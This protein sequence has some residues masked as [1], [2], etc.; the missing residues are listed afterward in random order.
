MAFTTRSE[1]S[2]NWPDPQKHQVQVALGGDFHGPG[3]PTTADRAAS[4]YGDSPFDGNYNIGLRIVCRRP[5]LSAPP[6]GDVA[7]LECPAWVIERGR[8]TAAR[9]RPEPPRRPILEMVKI[10]GG[11]F[12]HPETGVE[13][14]ISPFEMARCEVTFAKWL[15]VKRWAEAHG[16]AFGR[17][18]HMGSMYWYSFPHGPD[19]PVTF[20]TWHDCAVWCNA[21]S[22]ME[23]RTPFYYTDPARTKVYRHAFVY[24]P[25]KVAGWEIVDKKHPLKKYALPRNNEP[26]L[27]EKWDAD[28]YRLPTE[29]EFECAV[30][31]GTGT[32]YFWEETGGKR[33]DYVWCIYNSGG[34]THPVGQ[35]KPNPFGLYDLIGNVYEWSNSGKQPRSR[36]PRFDTNNPKRSRYWAHGLDRY[37]YSV[38]QNPLRMGGSWFWGGVRG[39]HQQF[40]FHDWGLEYMPDVGFRVVRCEPGTHP[41]NG[42]FPLVVPTLLKFD[43]K[44][45]EDLAGAAYRGS[46]RRDGVHQ[47]TGVAKLIGIKWKVHLG[48]PIKSSPVATG[49]LVYVGSASGFHAL[50]AETGREKWKVA[51]K[52]GVESA[53]CVAKGMVYFTGMDG[54]VYAV[55]AQNGNVKWKAKPK[56]FYGKPLMSGPAMAYGIVFVH[57]GGNTIG[58]DV[59][60]GHESWRCQRGRKGR[61]GVTLHSKYVITGGE[62]VTL[63]K[64]QLLFDT[65]HLIN[66][67][68]DADLTPCVVGDLYW[69]ASS[70][71]GGYSFAKLGCGDLAARR[72]RWSHFIEQHLPQPK[73]S[74]SSCSPAVWEGRVYIGVEKGVMYAFDALTG[75]KLQWEFNAGR[76][77]GLH[78]APSIAARSGTIYFGS[79]SGELFAVDA[80]TARQ[81]WQV[82]LGGAIETSPWPADGVLYVSCD[83]GHLY[84]LH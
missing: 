16:Y 57:V 53:A 79:Q 35:K 14:T 58:L 65:N 60:T 80:R 5:G 17:Q 3:D 73:R 26:W 56:G 84:A 77:N 67:T 74:Y 39:W 48:A 33:D 27:F 19:E 63:D 18:G 40:S 61:A 28:G 82:K 68:S 76:N 24:R 11:K 32:R 6:T 12:T 54:N 42:D 50:D 51:V 43:P 69:G 29:A 45:F 38:I 9:R 23:G 37:K 59:R 62:A 52:G 83:D 1:T 64:G 41:P 15:E 25:I 70:G 36:D 30:Q 78:S 7:E 66:W 20:I 44:D 47:T 4:P 49:G 31:A 21:L 55:A 34:T 8:K 22:E 75:K 71:R 10:P 2:G 81:M 72:T 13:V 46:I